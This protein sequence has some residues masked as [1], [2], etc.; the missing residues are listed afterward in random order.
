MTQLPVSIAWPPQ[1]KIKK[2][3]LAK[4]VKLRA[5]D[6]HCLEITIPTRFSLKHIPS[7]LEENKAWIIKHLAAIKIKNNDILP[8]QIFLNAL[9]ETWNIYY[10][11]CQS[12]LEMIIRPTREIVFVGKKV[13]KQIYRKKLIS[14]IKNQ[15]KKRLSVELAN[16]SQKMKLRYDTLTIRDQKTRWGSCTSDKSISLNYKLIFL[17]QRLMQHVI[18][19]ELCHTLHLNHSDEFWNK[20]AEFDADWRMHKRELRKADQ[21]LPDWM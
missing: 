21:Y 13:D 11:E 2:H 14:W 3:R 12:S 5:K 1:Y 17:P 20:V 10:D 4:H 15:A 9:N 18:I 8:H 16:L 6:D 19:H 7:I